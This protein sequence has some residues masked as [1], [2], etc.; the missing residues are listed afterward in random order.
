MYYKSCQLNKIEIVFLPDC[1]CLDLKIREQICRSPS[2]Y[3]FANQ[4]QD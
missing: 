3:G 1:M 2:L 4:N